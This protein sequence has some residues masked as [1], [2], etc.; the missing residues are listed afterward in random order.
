ME[1]EMDK[2]VTQ[3]GDISL[4]ARKIYTDMLRE[5][6]KKILELH[7]EGLNIIGI[8]GRA[9]SGTAQ[10]SASVDLSVIVHALKELAEGKPEDNPDSMLD[11]AYGNSYSID[12][13]IQGLEE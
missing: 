3:A 13:I 7:E 1:R 9:P 12:L 6:R 8:G 5:Y 10:D 4:K 11:I 2:L